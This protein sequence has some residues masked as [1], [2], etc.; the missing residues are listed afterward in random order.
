MYSQLQKVNKVVLTCRIGPTM[1]Q[2]VKSP[3]GLSGKICLREV[4]RVIRLFRGA[5]PKGKSDYPRDL[6]KANFSDNP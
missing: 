6:P 2:T 1:V 4:P 3:K 5:S